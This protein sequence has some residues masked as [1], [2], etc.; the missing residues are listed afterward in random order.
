MGLYKYLT[1][2]EKFLRM[3]PLQGSK[4][5]VSALTATVAEITSVMWHEKN[6]HS[7]MIIIIL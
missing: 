6:S 2:S 5:E 1:I 4:V 7:K 3:W